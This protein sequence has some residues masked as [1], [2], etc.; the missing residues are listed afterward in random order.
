MRSKFTTTFEVLLEKTENVNFLIVFRFRQSAVDGMGVDL[1]LRGPRCHELRYSF[2]FWD[3]A[4]KL[5][6]ARVASSRMWCAS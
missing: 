5:R 4:S 2:D 6:V 1:L 3:I